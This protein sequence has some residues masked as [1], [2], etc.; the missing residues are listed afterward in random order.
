M[1]PL[2]VS[3]DQRRCVCVG[4]GAVRFG[5]QCQKLPLRPLRETVQ[6]PDQKTQTSSAC[7]ARRLASWQTA[8]SRAA[9]PTGRRANVCVRETLRRVH[10]GTTDT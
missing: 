4:V 2:D 1:C 8:F 3:E 6:T 5:V 9:V 7:K 10:V